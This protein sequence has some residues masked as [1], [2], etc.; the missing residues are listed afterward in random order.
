MSKAKKSTKK[1]N[2]DPQKS[3]LLSAIHETA[4]GLRDTGVI[5][6]QTLKSFSY[7]VNHN[8][9][10]EH[11]ISDDILET[12]EKVISRYKD[13]VKNI[14]QRKKFMPHNIVAELE[15][16]SKQVEKLQKEVDELKAKK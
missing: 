7:E 10:K 6:D 8:V 1:N 16:L 2:Q 3:E 14:A 9:P 15:S 12:F 11:R 5:D 13:P 4:K